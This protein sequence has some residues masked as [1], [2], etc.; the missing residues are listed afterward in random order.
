MR[1]GPGRA[2]DTRSSTLERAG[3]RT[4]EPLPLQH[5]AGNRAMARLL[6]KHDEEQREPSEDAVPA[7]P[8]FARHPTD[9]AECFLDWPP[10]QSDQEAAEAVLGHG[11]GGAEPASWEQINGLDGE[12]AHAIPGP[13]VATLPTITAAAGRTGVVGWTSFP[14]ATA[15][16]P[17]FDMGSVSSMPG[18]MG[19]PSWAANPTW[20]QHYYEGDSVCIFLD[21]GR[22]LSTLTEGGKAVFFEFSAAMSALD[23]AAE[24]EHSNDIKQA[25]DLS[26]KE[27]ETVL[28]DHVIG[29]PFAS[30]GTKAEAE[31]LVLDKITSKLTHAGLGNDQ[32]KWA[33]IYETLYRKTL[34]RDN[35]GW[36]TFSPGA[37]SVNAAGEVTYK[38][39]AGTTS[40]NTMSSAA[41]IV[42]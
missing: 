19:P 11:L 41:L 6:Q 29:Q 35:K 33:A 23:S 5:H 31:Q 38:V 21:A 4:G 18:G 1:R 10:Q 13:S 37:R 8:V 14:L 24:A 16:A 25:R 20:K 26:I 22:H 40:I 34:T 42:Y 30:R 28:T 2:L 36:H 15:K 12:G 3:A 27:A 17:E 39:S 7:L 9:A 32:T